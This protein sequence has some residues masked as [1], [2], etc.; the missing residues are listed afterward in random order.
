M[1]DISLKSS[2]IFGLVECVFKMID[3]DQRSC[4][5]VDLHL[6]DVK[7]GLERDLFLAEKECGSSHDME[8]LAFV[9][10]VHAA[11]IR[12]DRAGLD[13]D[14][15]DLF[16]VAGDDVDLAELV[17]IILIENF[18]LLLFEVLGGELFAQSAELLVG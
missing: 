5:A 2:V 15:N 6:E 1:I 12:V 16:P 13:L 8:L 18:I 11:E 17:F 3:M 4:R 14:E 10:G 9:N 7:T